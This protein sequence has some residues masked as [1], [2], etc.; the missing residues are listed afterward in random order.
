MPDVVCSLTASEPQ[1]IPPG[2]AVYT[3]VRFPY[4]AI[5]S[6]DPEDM[7]P[8]IQPDGTPT[9][10]A[11]V[12]SGLIWPAHTAYARL[13]AMLQ[14][15]EGAYT[16][17]RDQFVRDPFGQTPDGPDTTCTQDRPPTP[18]GQYIAKSWSLFVHPGTPLAVAVRH[19][20][21]RP[22]RLLFAEFKLSYRLD[23]VTP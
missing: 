7:H 12:R 23:P 8:V 18:G 19:N 1:T 20:A 15:E 10:F 3:V 4:G 16:E 5:E 14:W 6:W 2:G 22:V 11:D 21:S 9:S 17:L 13:D